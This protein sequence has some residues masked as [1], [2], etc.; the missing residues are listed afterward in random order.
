M[1][2]ETAPIEY[3]DLV[4]DDD[5]VV[6]R[7]DRA[8]IYSQKLSNYRVVNAF[9]VNSQ[10]QFWI[11][12][13]TA[14]KRIFPLCLDFS[15]GGHV[16]SGESYDESFRR[17]TFEELNIDVDKVGFR[18]LGHLT[19]AKDGVSSFMNIYELKG[20]VAPDY[21]PNDFIGAEWLTPVELLDRIVRGE[22][23]K[24]D[25]EKVIKSFY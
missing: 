1:T 6:G 16:E 18:L 23:V 10:G 4:N 15:V 9:I 19:P 7:E 20:E 8:V 12:R 5:Q 11:P 22:K 13:R 17:E 21:N 14:H 25:L 3:L 24:D 2:Q